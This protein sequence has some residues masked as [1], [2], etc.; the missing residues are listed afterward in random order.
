MMRGRP[1]RL[2]A[3]F[4]QPRVSCAVMG[5]LLVLPQSLSVIGDYLAWGIRFPFLRYQDS[6][7]GPGIIPLWRE[8]QYIFTG[9]AGGRTAVATGLWLA[10]AVLL[11][12][13]AALVISWHYVGN[14]GHAKY[15]GP[16]LFAAG[17]LFLL[18]GIAQYGPL[19]SGP[20]GYEVPVG[21]PVPWY[22]GWQFMRAAKAVAEGE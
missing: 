1:Q 9:Q 15:I 14:E 7:Y 13:A 17:L 16:L 12:A 6:V 3:I 4:R 20:S 11:L 18:R 5:L 10:G 21:V 2:K 19:L 22:C 8:F